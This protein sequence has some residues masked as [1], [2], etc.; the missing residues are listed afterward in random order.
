MFRDLL[1]DPIEGRVHDLEG[2]GTVLYG[3]QR[4]FVL[5]R[6]AALSK[7]WTYVASPA[8]IILT[9]NEGRGTGSLPG[10]KN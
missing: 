6:T 2:R 10:P 1:S 7:D 3:D 4:V 8:S 9:N 5:K